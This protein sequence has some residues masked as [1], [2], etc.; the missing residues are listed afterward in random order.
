MIHKVAVR[1]DATQAN[2]PQRARKR[3]QQFETKHTASL[4]SGRKG[5]RSRLT[6]GQNY[7]MSGMELRGVSHCGC[8]PGRDQGVAVLF[9]LAAQRQAL[10]GARRPGLMEVGH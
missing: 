2:A 5:G 10:A 9:L 7:G 4:A 6:Q 8:A 1:R 3:R